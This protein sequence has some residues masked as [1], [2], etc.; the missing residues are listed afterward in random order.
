MQ[1]KGTQRGFTIIEV[2]MVVAITGLLFV[3]LLSGIGFA[4]ERQRFS[5]TVFSLQSYLQLQY[6]EVVNVVNNRK[7]KQSCTDPT[8]KTSGS[9]TGADECTVL[10]RAVVLLYDPALEATVIKTHMVIGTKD[11]SSAANMS[12]YDSIIASEPYVLGDV[13]SDDR[14]E[15]AWG[16]TVKDLHLK[17]QPLPSP[18]T[19]PFMF[20]ILRSPKTGAVDTY[21][22]KDSLGALPADPILQTQETTTSWRRAL[23]TAPTTSYL[24]TMDE[25]IQGCIKSNS[26]VGI[27]AALVIEPTGSQDGVITLFDEERN[28]VEVCS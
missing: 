19:E 8:D 20:A 7:N 26:L 12:A 5:D 3:A 25:E 15:V 13:A 21:L 22:L 24:Q 28:G 14:Y 6:N 16:G 23:N 1:G 27:V 4:V 10:G 2:S 11:P 18:A 9:F 17:G